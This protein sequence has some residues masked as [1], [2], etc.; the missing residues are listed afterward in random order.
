MKQFLRF[1]FADHISREQYDEL[2][3]LCSHLL[4]EQRELKEQLKY[5]TNIVEKCIKVR[6]LDF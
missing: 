5:Q 2:N 3:N 6:I 4:Q 1:K